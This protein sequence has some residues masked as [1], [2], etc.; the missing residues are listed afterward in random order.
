MA[1]TPLVL[2]P[3]IVRDGSRNA[4]QGR[5]YDC[6]NVR[7][8]NGFPEKIGGWTKVTQSMLDGPARGVAG[9]ATLAGAQLFAFGTTGKLNLLQDDTLFDITPFR[10]TENLTDPFATTLGSAIVTVTDTAHGLINGDVV[11]F[12]GASA[13]GGLTIDG[14]YTG[15]RVNENTY[16]IDAGSNA[17]STATGGGP[18]TA[19]YEISQG[20]ITSGETT[21]FGAGG[22][23]LGG[24]GGVSQIFTTIT[25][26]RVWQLESWGEDLIGTYQGG[27]LFQWDATNG[28]S[29]R[30]QEITGPPAENNGLYIDSAN[31]HLFALGCTNLSGAF[32]PMNIRWADQ[33]SLTDWAPTDTNDAGDRRLEKGTKIMR[34]RSVRN[35]HL[36]LTNRAAY[37]MRYIGGRFI[38]SFREM[39]DQCGAV[40][41][42]AVTAYDGVAYWMGQESFYQFDGSVRPL[43]CDIH[44]F[45]FNY[46]NVAESAKIFAAVNT[47]FA[48]VTWFYVSADATEVDRYVA[49]NV[50]NPARP[51]WTRGTVARTSWFDNA[52]VTKFPVATDASGNIFL[53]E[54]GTT[55]DGSAIPYFLE[56]G[57][58]ML[59]AGEKSM[60]L[61]RIMP[62]FKRISGE[63][64]FTVAARRYAGSTQA[65]TKTTTITEGG[66]NS[67][68]NAGRVM[69]FKLESAAGD[70]RLGSFYYDARAHKG[71]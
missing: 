43:Y 55:G 22:F 65:R 70:F 5:Y 14:A 58:V 2:P 7:W 12:S 52:D 68:R 17:T 35:G 47:E 44:N 71:R 16:T 24:F 34:A 3:G 46:I 29:T 27:K 20:V 11:V 50:Q 31:R 40:G 4:A 28:A 57:D 45:I 26:P 36:I 30:A 23:G 9:W 42:N 54:T 59:G 33:G 38:Y 53:Q 69:T 19:S 63:H 1:L 51:A 8:H 49:V 48:E 60:H 56:S 66:K 41:P 62:D 67:I 64:T 15:T 18:V 13:V 37:L 21:G 61:S 32:D 6:E 25:E 10:A 39:A